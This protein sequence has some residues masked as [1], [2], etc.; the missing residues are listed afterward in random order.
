MGLKNISKF[1]K[2][3]KAWDIQKKVLKLLWDGRRTYGL[4]AILFFFLFFYTFLHNMGK[5]NLFKRS[6]LNFLRHRDKSRNEVW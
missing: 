4:V 1:T 2:A 5:G 3:T 6:A